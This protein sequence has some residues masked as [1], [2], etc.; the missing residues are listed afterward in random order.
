VR[1]LL[2]GPIVRANIGS[3][4]LLAVGV[5]PFAAVLAAVFVVVLLGRYALT[6]KRPDDLDFPGVKTDP[7][8]EAIRVALRGASIH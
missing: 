6:G 4:I 5:A 8:A 2:S 3:R 1:A 7:E